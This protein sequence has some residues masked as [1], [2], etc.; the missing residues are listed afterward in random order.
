MKL[1]VVIVV[2]LYSA[3]AIETSVEE[4]D[5]DVIYGYPDEDTL[6]EADAIVNNE[7]PFEMN[8]EPITIEARTTVGND[9]VDS[10]DVDDI[11]VSGMAK[12]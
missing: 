5:S 1:L 4:A 6:K 7:V 11:S 8:T 2:V 3:V 9:L 12:K 10:E